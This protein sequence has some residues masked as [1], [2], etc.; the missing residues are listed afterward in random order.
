MRYNKNQVLFNIQI[1]LEKGELLT[2][3]KYMLPWIN[4]LHDAEI[5]ETYKTITDNYDLLLR[6]F[7]EGKSDPK[8]NE[9]HNKLMREAYE[10]FDEVYLQMRIKTNSSKEYEWLRA[11]SNKD[12]ANNQSIVPEGTFYHFFLAKSWTKE[13][14]DEY[15]QLL[16]S[17][18]LNDAV[19]AEYA[20]MLQ[21]MRTFSADAF[22]TLA[23]TVD[24]HTG[25]K[26]AIAMVGLSLASCKYGVRVEKFYPEITDRCMQ[27]LKNEELR[28]LIC[29]TFLQLARSLKIQRAVEVVNDMQQ[30]ILKR[31]GNNQIDNP[32]NIINVDDDMPDW[33]EG[34]SSNL[35][36][37]ADTLRKL[38]EEKVDVNYAHLYTSFR[39]P[40]FLKNFDSFFRMF[41][42][43]NKDVEFNSNSPLGEKVVRIV[44]DLDMCECD[45]HA[46]CLMY[47]NLPKL[48]EFGNTSNTDSPTN[49][50]YPISDEQ[51]KLIMG[52]FSLGC[53]GALTSD[54]AF[55][56]SVISTLYRFVMNNDFKYELDWHHLLFDDMSNSFIWQND[57]LHCSEQI[58]VADIYF[59]MMEPLFALRVLKHYFHHMENP[60]ADDLAA[61]YRRLGY[62][63]EKAWNDDPISYYKKALIL[64]PHDKWVLWRLAW[65]YDRTYEYLRALE[66]IDELIALDGEKCK[67]LFRRAELLSQIGTREDLIEAL[68][69]VE[70]LYPDYPPVKAILDCKKGNYGSALEFY[71]NTEDTF[72]PDLLL[73]IGVPASEVTIL[74]DLIDSVER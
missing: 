59:E 26:R 62:A 12:I 52:Q 50:D 61:I 58:A 25:L 51:L 73:K 49:Q 11:L 68:Y 5:N 6:Y 34:A 14:Q 69:K 33:L 23:D 32:L 44:A 8:R 64:H 18:Q 22:M 31:L 72:D 30:A 17:D 37:D 28:H 36:A 65:C 46:I 21:L 56:F 27:L 19:L 20:L 3:L 43:Y 29:F 2:G 24:Y 71:N 55:I 4:K 60:S 66:V 47:S 1:S 63:A 7:R 13:L 9:L 10:L 53:V 40:F 15:H 45:K 74:A 48:P 35:Q 41:N 70:M 54:E 38:A 67:Y 57:K 39:F 16:F 42:P